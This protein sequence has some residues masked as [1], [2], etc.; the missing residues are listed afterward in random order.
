M[1]CSYEKWPNP[2]RLSGIILDFAGILPS[3]DENFPNEHT[4]VGQPGNVV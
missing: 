1:M 4:Q 2:T 3:S